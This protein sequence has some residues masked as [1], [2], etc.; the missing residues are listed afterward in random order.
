M[1]SQISSDTLV[2]KLNAQTV[3]SVLRPEVEHIL[4]ALAPMVV[5]RVGQKRQEKF[6]SLVEALVE[7]VQ[8][9]EVDLRR[10]RMQAAALKAILE[11]AEWLTAEQ[12]GALG[13]F[14]K[15]NLAAPAHRWKKDGK[16]F[17]V[18][19]EGQ[20]RFPR[21]SLDE[22][23]RP[24]PGMAP[25]LSALGNISPWR[26]AAWFESRNAWLGDRRPKELIASAPQSV[27][28]AARHYL[29]GGHG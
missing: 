22:T 4:S 9:R 11:S 16:I 13:G 6:R 5:E 24:L 10:A 27:L 20:D 8:L 25:V 21:Y 17:A 23:L 2:L 26:V 15:S 14:S 1:A 18:G 12:I 3:P 29:S 19:Y 28:E 7:D